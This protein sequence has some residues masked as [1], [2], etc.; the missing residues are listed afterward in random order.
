MLTAVMEEEFNALA[1]GVSGLPFLWRMAREEIAEDVRTY[2]RQE[3]E[4]IG[5]WQPVAAELPFSAVPI[6]IPGGPIGFRG[7]VDRLDQDGSRLR[8]I[9]YKT[10]ATKEEGHAYR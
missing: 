6:A 5:D 1:E 9:D 2:L 8:V 10:G 3:I 4:E 7:Q